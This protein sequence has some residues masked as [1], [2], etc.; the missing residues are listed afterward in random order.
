M[1][2]EVIDKFAALTTA[3][4]GLVAALAW[5]DTIKA[6][7]KEYFGKPDAV[8]PMLV[9]AMTVTIF[10]IIATKVIGEVSAKAKILDL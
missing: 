9:Y 2:D 8:T 5:N 4:F 10:A 3:S 1:K 7:I 6:I